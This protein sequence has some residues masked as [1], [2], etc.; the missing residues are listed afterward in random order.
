MRPLAVFD[1][2]GVLADVRHRVHH[3][4]G[5]QQDWR[6][7]FAA[8]PDD[9][10]HPEGAALVLEAAVECEI[11][12]VTGRPEWCRSDTESWLRAHGLP[13]GTVAMRRNGDYRPARKAKLRLLRELAAG[14]TVAVV[15]DDDLEVCAAYEQ[16][17][18]PVLRAAWAPRLS[19]LER[20]QEDQGRT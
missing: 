3:L 12:Y 18:W 8:A 11:A 9:P 17:G 1:L 13:D 7:F 5:P 6:A 2:D 15:V 4:D 19:A 10:V 14:R 20:A 16:A